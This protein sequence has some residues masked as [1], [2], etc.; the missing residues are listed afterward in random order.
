MIS[1]PCPPLMPYESSA[2]QYTVLYSTV[3][4]TAQ[5]ALVSPVISTTFAYIIF[6][7]ETGQAPTGAGGEVAAS[8]MPITFAAS[9]WSE[10]GESGE[11]G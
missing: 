11:L 4:H 9:I 1:I 7:F 5:K 10:R 3:Q 6:S 2:L 8:M